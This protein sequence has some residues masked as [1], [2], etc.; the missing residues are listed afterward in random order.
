MRFIDSRIGL[1]DNN[2]KVEELTK[3][4][5]LLGNN[6]FIEEFKNTDLYKENK[7]MNLYNFSELIKE[8]EKK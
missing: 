7:D 1:I 6:L 3:F 8:K 5:E 4:F 2:F